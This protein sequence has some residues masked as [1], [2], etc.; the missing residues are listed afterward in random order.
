MHLVLLKMPRKLLTLRS[1][2]TCQGSDSQLAIRA[3]EF[4]PEADSKLWQW[5]KNADEQISL[6]QKMRGH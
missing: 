6:V 2:R 3:A 5:A 4:G 1:L